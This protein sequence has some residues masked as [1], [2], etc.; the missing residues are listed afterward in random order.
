MARARRARAGAAPGFDPGK[1]AFLDETRAKAAM[2]RAR[3]RA[4][5]GGRLVRPV[6][7]GRWRTTTF[8]RGLRTDGPVAPLVLDGATNGPAFLAWV[9]RMLAPALRP[10]GTVVADNLGSHKVAGVREA[11]EARGASLLRPPPHSPDLNPI[12]PAFS[13][14]ERLLRAAAARTAGALEAA[15]GA[16]LRHFTPA[17]C[18]NHLRH[19]GYA[20]SGR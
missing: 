20:Q 1:L 5:R 18:A 7:Y 3:G 17:E 19:C 16:A 6:P 15:I 10:G 12:E 13:K 8:L 4:P 14:L 11:I 2:T 9:G